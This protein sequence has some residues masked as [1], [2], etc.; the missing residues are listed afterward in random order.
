MQAL[1]HKH[2]CDHAHQGQD[3]LYELPS[4]LPEGRPQQKEFE[5]TPMV[6]NPD[7]PIS[8]QEL[9]QD[10]L[11]R[12]PQVVKLR[13][14]VDCDDDGEVVRSYARMGEGPTAQ[15]LPPPHSY[16]HAEEAPQATSL[17]PPK[18]RESRFQSCTDHEM[19]GES[20]DS[21]VEHLR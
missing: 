21:H 1:S 19:I 9:K 20:H 5:E 14:L 18:D 6:V 16:S 10:M 4:N 13:K 2:V 11:T 17:S 3:F 15:C 7:P 8:D 12:D